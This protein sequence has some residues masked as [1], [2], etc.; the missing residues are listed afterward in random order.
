MKQ[1]SMEEVARQAFG[2]QQLHALQKTVIANILAG[3]RQIVLLPTGYGK[4]LCFLVPAL[5]LDGAT[6]VIY[7]LLA[8]MA[9]Q[10]RRMER[11][12][13]RAV[14]LRGGQTRTQRQ[15]AL[16]E[17]R[18][19]K[20]QVV[21]TNPEVLQQPALVTELATCRLSHIAIDEAHC[22]SEWGDSFR[23][24]Y[25]SLGGVI[26][27]LGVARVTAFTATA[28]PAVLARIRTLLFAES[29]GSAGTGGAD[30]SDANARVKLVQ[31]A[32]D[33]PNLRYRVQHAA[34]KPM[35]LL[36]LALELP[37]PLLVFCGTRHNAEATARL[38]QAFF[39][40]QARLQTE[41][42]TP[43]KVR[44]YHAG[45]TKQEKS[46]VEQWFFHSSDGILCATC[47]Y[48]MGVDKPDIRTCI[49][50]EAPSKIEFFIQ[51]AG[52]AGRSGEV[53]TSVL[54]WNKADARRFPALSGYAQ[55]TS[56]RR[57][58]LLDYLHGEK[59]VCSGCD[60]CVKNG[61][62]HD[63]TAQLASA[64]DAAREL[65]L[66]WIGRNRRRYTQAESVP[67]LLTQLNAHGLA[68][69]GLQVW[70]VKALL[71]ILH[72]LKEERK[73]RL[74]GLGTKTR[75]RL[76][77]VPQRKRPPASRNATLYQRYI[78][79]HRHRLHQLRLHFRR[80]VRALELALQRSS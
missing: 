18:S 66:Q 19:G 14:M 62:V 44:F 42:T 34:A 51:E 31:G 61:T 23:P 27:R 76:D 77:L 40:D 67:L 60:V 26:A 21:L 17:I 13:I 43:T 7:P 71:T 47:A 72:Q 11:A 30:A 1:K 57:Q 53:A 75:A 8:L 63:D 28:G 38:L 70:D 24:A 16:E 46:E 32:Y 33:R 56:C 12:G 35:A 74:I 39:S 45:L 59:A 64:P 29:T 4:T 69:V 55:S 25:L 20:A 65:V 58:Y 48:G 15:Q 78:T 6:L 3:K 9:D 54:L 80:L 41:A 36:P 52:R 22:V 73:I 10:Q 50:L 49:H 79:L 5:M 37:K 68:T 2:I